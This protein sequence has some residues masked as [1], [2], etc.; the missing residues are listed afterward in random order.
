[1]AKKTRK[2]IIVEWDRVE[3]INLAFIEWLQNLKM[4]FTIVEKRVRRTKQQIQE[5]AKKNEK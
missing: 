4:K 3:G 2:Q 5:S 1:M